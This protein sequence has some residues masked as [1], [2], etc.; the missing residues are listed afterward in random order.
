[1]AAIRVPPA[2]VLVDGKFFRLAGERFSLKGVTYGP[3]APNGFREPFPSPGQAA[4]DFVQIRALEA[5]TLRVYEPPP[6]WLL[7]LA[8]EHQLRLFIDIPWSKHLCFLDSP[9]MKARAQEAVR[10]GVAACRQHPAVFAYSVVNEIP[11]EIVRWSGVPAVTAF[12]EELVAIAKETDPACLCTFASYPPTEYLLPQ[13]LDFVC[14]NLFLHQRPA[15]DRY[16]ARLQMLADTR[17][18]VI[19]ECG[20]DALREGEARQ[21]EILAWQVESTFRGGAAGL[22]LFS[23]TDD[24]HRGGRPIEDWA[25]G[26]TTRDRRPK[27]SFEGVRRQ[28]HTA[29][30]FPLPRCPKVSVVVACYNGE[31]TLALCLESL[32][33]LRYPDYEVILVDD[34]STDATPRIAEGFSTVRYVRQ[35]HLGLSV[36]RNTG[37]AAATGEVIAF[38]D[39][40]CRADADWLH[41]LVGELLDGRFVGVGGTTCCRRRIRGWRRRCWCLPAA[42]PMSC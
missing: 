30:R 35:D 38:T 32:T 27:P 28:F 40:D 2:N 41:F 9:S 22:F 14:F 18:L 15:L 26:L 8:A 19:G 25:F 39:A 37:I 33:L 1:M 20:I 4:R 11:A 42:R 12:I 10:D 29:P 31:P 7:D 23:F 24:W 13:N 16:L 6:R 21:A 34:G 5:N 3:F 36:A 17:P